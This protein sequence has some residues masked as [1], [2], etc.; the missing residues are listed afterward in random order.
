MA[1]DGI[2]EGVASG[3]GQSF[4]YNPLTVSRWGTTVTFTARVVF[5]PPQSLTASSGPL[6]SYVVER[7]TLDCAASTLEHLEWGAY[8]ADGTK[9]DIPDPDA[10]GPHAFEAGSG[11]AAFQAK[12]CPAG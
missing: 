7:V 5:D 1:Q 10:P 6:A 8:A 3:G 4:G 11:D 12:L 9:L 2:W